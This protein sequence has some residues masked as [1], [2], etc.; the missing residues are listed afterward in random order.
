[1]ETRSTQRRANANERRQILYYTFSST[2]NP[3]CHPAKC[4]VRHGTCMNNR[5]LRALARAQPSSAWWPTFGASNMHSDVMLC[6]LSREVD[7]CAPAPA[8]EWSHMRRPELMTGSLSWGCQRLV[9]DQSAPRRRVARWWSGIRLI[10]SFILW[11]WNT[12]LL[13]TRYLKRWAFHWIVMSE[14]WTW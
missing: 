12:I 14:Q 4:D 7:R 11:M 2:G 8:P 10:R 6:V 13:W 1:M 5:C 3:C 9:P